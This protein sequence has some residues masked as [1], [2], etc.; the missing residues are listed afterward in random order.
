MSGVYKKIVI[1][2]G[3]SVITRENGLPDE[4]VFRS[5][6]DQIAALKK[7]GAEVVLVSSGAVASGRFRIPDSRKWSR[8]VQRQVLAAAGQPVLMGLYSRLFDEHALICA[9]VLATKE[10]FRD[11][12]HYT[13]M[14]NCLISLLRHNIVP[15]VNENDV[16]AVQELMF[17]DNDELA[18]LVATMLDADLLILL[19]SID[20]LLDFSQEPPALVPVVHP[21]ERAAFQSL[22]GAKRSSAGRGGMVSKYRMAVKAAMNGIEVF[23]ANGKKTNVVTDIANGLP[24]GTRFAAQRKRSSVKRWIEFA[25][26]E[27]KGSVSVDENAARALWQTVCSLLPVGI[28]KVEGNFEKG[29]LVEIFAPDGALIG[30]G[31]AQYGADAAQKWVGVKGKKPLVHY[32]YLLIY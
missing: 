22:V 25:H 4:A 16:V 32:D 18:A 2:V 6:T 1:K 21:G 13:N 9:Q 24:E 11:K 27:P 5:I 31:I 30:I 28:S 23:I 3:S 10:D 14:K 20:G 29:D 26:R 19:S 17:T 8:T 7:Q 12:S 15:V